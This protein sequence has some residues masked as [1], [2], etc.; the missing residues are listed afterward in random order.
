MKPAY[1]D[2]VAPP[3]VAE[4]VSLL[5]E[6]GTEASVLAGGQ[7][8]LIEMRYRRRRPAILIDVNRVAGL[9]GIALDPASAR[10]GAL[11]RHADLERA[12]F[13]DPLAALFRLVAPNVAHPPIRARGTFAGSLAWAHPAAEWCAL[14][15]ALN[16]EVE[17]RGPYGE[18]RVPA[19]AWFLGPFTTA[20][21]PDELVT[22]VRLPRLGPGTAVRFAEHRR[23]HASFAL[24]A[25][26][27]AVRLAAER[28]AWVRI[29]LANAADVPLRA[30]EAEAV[31]I[32]ERAGPGPIAEAAEVAGTEADPVE[33]P[34]ASVP[35]RR[36][37]LRTL[38][39]RCLTEAA[40]AAAAEA[41][42]R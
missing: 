24:A 31:L 18:R 33:E 40:E 42:N 8:L 11:V 17:L 6:H 36:H 1:F 27:V 38:V 10:L 3:S 41:A 39:R 19:G 32:G 9:S 22:G 37:V 26:V 34:Y 29:G 35:Y 23:T 5:G 16:A 30:V 25:V 2:Y 14:A 13:A 12:R 15:A 20:R 7:S 28:V 21:L 4:T